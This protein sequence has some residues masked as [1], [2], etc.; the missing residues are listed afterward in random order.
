MKPTRKMRTLV[1][2]WLILYGVAGVY[3]AEAAANSPETPD[4]CT[5]ETE[6]AGEQRCASRA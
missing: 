4:F 2:C 3:S 6:S 5:V 1:A